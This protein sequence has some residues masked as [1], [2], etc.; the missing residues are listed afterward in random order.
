MNE[1]REINTMDMPNRFNKLNKRD[2]DTMLEILPN[3]TYF[4]REPYS[5]VFYDKFQEK[6]DILVRIDKCIDEYYLVIIP[7]LNC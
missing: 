2:I 6:T 3:K 7:N 5:I 1:Y 4:I